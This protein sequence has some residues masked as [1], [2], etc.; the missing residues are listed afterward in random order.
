MGDYGQR[1]R[2]QATYDSKEQRTARRYFTPE[3]MV[4]RFR[5]SDSDMEAVYL[6]A[7]AFN[8]NSD[9]FPT[10]EDFVSSYL[11]VDQ[12]AS[13]SSHETGIKNAQLLRL[14]FKVAPLLEE[15]ID[16]QIPDEI[17][18]QCPYC[19]ENTLNAYIGMFP[20]YDE[21]EKSFIPEEG[22][23]LIGLDIECGC[24]NY[25]T[26]D[27]YIFEQIALNSPKIFGVEVE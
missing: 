12:R 23:R 24:S 6:A 1:L 13:A 5:P 2:Q 4:K 25:T 11:D 16:S 22:P 15:Q 26:N 14:A 8:V 20:V 19:K 9:G 18:L 3:R 21:R 17:A 27:Y 10:A 7:V